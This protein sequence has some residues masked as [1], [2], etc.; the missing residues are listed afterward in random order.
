MRG[1]GFRGMKMKRW[2]ALV[3]LV[4]VVV[5]LPALPASAATLVVDDAGVGVDAPDCSAGVTTH[6]TIQG[7][8]TDA[9]P[10]DT[11]FVCPGVYAHTATPGVTVDK[12]LTI[13]SDG[14]AGAVVSGDTKDGSVVNGTDVLFMVTASGVTIEELTVDLGNED[15]DYDVGVFS[16]DD[17][18][19]DNLVIQDSVFRFAGFGAPAGKGEQ[20][21]HLGGGTGNTVQ[22]NDLETASANSTLYL[23]PATHTSLT[24]SDNTIGT[25]LDGDGGGTSVNSFGPVVNSTF[26]MNTFTTTGIGIYLGSGPAA[27]DNVTVTHNSF[28]GTTSTHATAGAAV[29]ITSEVD[30][31]ATGNINV[32]YNTFTTSAGKAVSIFDWD[33]TTADVNG[34]TINVNRNAINLD[35][36]DGL[37]VG[38][39]VA[40]TVDGEC[41][42]WGAATGPGPVGPGAGSSVSAGV[43]FT[44]WLTTAVLD[45]VCAGGLPPPP[46]PPPPPPED[47]STTTTVGPGGTAS[48]DHSGDGATPGTPVETSVTSPN[49]GVIQIISGPAGPAPTGFTV[50]G[51][52]I[53]ITAPDATPEDPLE[54]E[55]EIDASVIPP[56]TDLSEVQVFKDG[57]AV[58]DCT[59]AGA[60]PD[61]CVASRTLQADGDVV[62]EVRTSA[63][64]DWLFAKADETCHGL[65]ATIVGTGDDDVLI[66]TSGD[67]V[68]WAGAGDDMVDGGGGNDTICL[69]PGRDVGDGSAGDDTVLG[70]GGRD[71]IHGGD[72]DDLL[73][74][75]GRSDRLH[76]GLGRDQL[77]GG[78]GADRLWA[79]PGKDGVVGG[80][81][82]DRLFGNRHRDRLVGHAGEDWLR[83]GHGHDRL[84]GGPGDDNL[85][86]GAGDDI[87]KGR[88]GDDTMTGAWGDDWLKGGA[89]AD[90]AT[91][92]TGTDTCMAETR[93]H[94]EL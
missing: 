33:P 25:V 39:G 87:I 31:V 83:G 76:G 94:C 17:G 14:A 11:V 6:T 38:L 71:L 85:G 47:G 43:D 59:G 57:V 21:I 69:G 86:G 15:S 55:F 63:A 73:K 36:T 48:T 67:D 19:V 37:I 89:D 64:S 1:R 12:A 79:G 65:A 35:N 51:T 18:S 7:A 60:S 29:V 8:V 41:N 54:I 22:R 52:K 74:G 45:G 68:I 28:T 66:G 78:S 9:A 42:W 61:P 13:T 91:G 75:G 92:G 20:L 10:A 81:G 5:V 53:S 26:S 80:E 58:P 16:P 90:D 70:Q 56:G 34:A 30:G 93:L 88:T 24:F 3:A 44:P 62:I 82:A 23:G 32:T 46:P 2:A 72:G 40:G 4:V 49:A 77:R 27:T 84:I 50:L